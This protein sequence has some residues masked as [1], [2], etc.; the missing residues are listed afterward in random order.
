MIYHASGQFLYTKQGDKRNAFAAVFEEK[1]TKSLWLTCNN[2]MFLPST[3]ITH[4]FSSFIKINSTGVQQDSVVLGNNKVLYGK[5]LNYLS[6]NY[7]L[8]TN[9]S[10]TVLGSNFYEIPTLIKHD[11]NFNKIKEIG[12]DTIKQYLYPPQNPVVLNNKLYVFWAQYNPKKS[13]LFKLDLNLNIEDSLTINGSIITTMIEQ[14][15]H[16][17]I[18]GDGFP[19]GSN[20]GRVQV[21][22]LDTNFNVL[23]RLNFD[24]ITYQN[25]G[26]LSTTGIWHGPQA[27]LKLSNIK[28]AIVGSFPIVIN[29]NCDSDEK[30]VYAIVENNKV[31]KGDYWNKDSNTVREGFRNYNS[32]TDK[33]GA[34][35][36]TSATIG[37]SNDIALNIN[38]TPTSILITKTDTMGTIIWVKKFATPNYYY[39]PLGLCVTSDSDVV[40]CGSRYDVTD[41]SKFNAFEGFVLKLDKNGEVLQVGINKN[42]GLQYDVMLYPNPA[43]SE[44]TIKFYTPFNSP[45][46]LAITN[47]MG[48]VVLQQSISSFL[49]PQTI[50]V[51]QLANGVYTVSLKHTKGIITRKIVI[52]N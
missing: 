6:Y 12:L 15:N 18:S 11:E 25:P 20:L 8:Y 46:Q 9:R 43:S 38:Y 1:M 27:L 2:F 14:N 19:N 31:I 32:L 45:V 51:K 21:A 17:L 26:C 30:M 16:L 37:I 47:L 40:V 4:S 24:S 48:E 29:G 28:Y 44:L 23:Y 39:E 50:N 10:D 34:Y 35:F 5:T 22:T 36:Y 42:N 52:A 3:S 33:Q 41:A 49:E 13:K 7:S